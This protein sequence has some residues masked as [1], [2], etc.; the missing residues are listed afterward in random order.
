MNC[1]TPVPPSPANNQVTNVRKRLDRTQ[2]GSLGMT[3]L[4]FD[5]AKLKANYGIKV[6]QGEVTA[7]DTLIG[8]VHY[9]VAGKAAFVDYD[10]LVISPGIDFLYPQGLAGNPA[11]QNEIVHA[12]KAGPQT[13]KLRSQLLAMPTGGRFV[14]TIPPAPYRCP[15]GPTSAPAWSPTG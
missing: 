14:M 12:W 11:A 1:N 6:V 7:I 13:E 5:Y 2:T 15:R 8:R 9:P 3:S 10:R 4:Y